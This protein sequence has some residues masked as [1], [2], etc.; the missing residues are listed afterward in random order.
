MAK[1]KG[2]DKGPFAG[3]GYSELITPINEEG[4][5]TGNDPDT[6]NVP[7]NLDPP[8]PLGLTHGIF[9]KSGRKGSAPPKG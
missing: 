4:N 7:S 3:G 2:M 1:E 5:R 6:H 8:D 9:G